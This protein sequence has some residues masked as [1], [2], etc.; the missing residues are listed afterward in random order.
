MLERIVRLLAFVSPGM[1]LLSAVAALAAF[2]IGEIH[3]ALLFAGG[4]AG[5]AANYAL[6]RSADL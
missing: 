3:L 4:A 1:A 5:W 2:M 6:A